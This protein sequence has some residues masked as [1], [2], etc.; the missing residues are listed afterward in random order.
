MLAHPVNS[1]FVML[2]MLEDVHRAYQIVGMI[3]AKLWNWLTIY[4][5]HR[6]E[7]LQ[8]IGEKGAHLNCIYAASLCENCQILAGTRSKL[9]AF[10]SA[11]FLQIAE[12][13]LSEKMGSPAIEP[14]LSFALQALLGRDIHNGLIAT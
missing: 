10:E 13:K 1:R 11:P 2:D 3:E 4:S 8:S 12:E 7:H 6:R 14:I 9:Q 5:S